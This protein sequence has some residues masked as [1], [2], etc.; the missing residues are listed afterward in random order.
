[1]DLA[2]DVPALEARG[3]GGLFVVFWWHSLPLGGAEVDPGQLPM[4]A[5]AVRA[6]GADVAAPAAAARLLPHGFRP[7]PPEKAPPPDSPPALDALLAVNDPLDSACARVEAA[8][9]A[10]PP[11]STSVVV[12]TRDRPDA[13]RR[14]LAALAALDPA[15]E[16]VVVVDNGPG[17]ATRRV[18]EEAEGVPGLRYVAEPRPGLSAARNAGLRASTGE[19]VAYTDDDVRVHP[20]W[21]LR[22]RAAFDAEDVWAATGLV[23]PAEA[24]TEAQVLFERTHGGTRW[25][26]RP[27]TFDGG[28][29]QRM[30]RYGAPV[31]Q[32]G[33]G[34]NMAFRRS[35]FEAVGGF[36]ERLGAGASGCSEDSEAWYRVLAAGGRC[37]YEPAAVVF[38]EHRREGEALRSQMH[39]YLRGHV[40]ALLVQHAAHGDRGSLRRA[41]ATLP[42]YYGGR[43]L[44]R[45]LGRG[46]GEAHLGAQ[47]RGWA[48]GFGYYARHRRRPGAPPLDP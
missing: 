12:C 11:L 18:V 25:S 4:P 10:A 1:V 21:S 20:R 31:W 46:G 39:A 40:A 43:A 36:D 44:R 27:Q 34:A 23:L 14:C 45:A 26:Y 35:A 13:L 19:I 47:I 48:A 15:P 42:R 9:R 6:W 32:I 37:R 30:R 33:A 3:A 24:E 16:E 22:L 41:V 2:G 38:H 5:A 8:E 17:G 7:P 28:F 29:F